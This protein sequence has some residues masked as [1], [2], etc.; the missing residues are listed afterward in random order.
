[1]PHQSSNAGS[2]GLSAFVAR[3]TWE[4]EVYGSV[5]LAGVALFT[6]AIPAN[7]KFATM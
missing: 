1:M 3:K 4:R 7:R 5:Q 6:S 2:R